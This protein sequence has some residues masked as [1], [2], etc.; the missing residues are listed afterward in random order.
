MSNGF[1]NHKGHKEHITRGARKKYFV[2]FVLFVV[3]IPKRI[4]KSVIR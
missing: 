3:G 4:T 1:I 2:N